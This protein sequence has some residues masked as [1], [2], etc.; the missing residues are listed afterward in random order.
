MFLRLCFITVGLLIAITVGAQ[1][2]PDKAQ[3]A[4]VVERKAARQEA[5]QK[6]KVGSR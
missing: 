1:L 6:A 3:R 2:A 5:R 4:R